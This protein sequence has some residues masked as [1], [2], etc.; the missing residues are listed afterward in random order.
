MYTKRSSLVQ[1]TFI[2]FFAHFIIPLNGMEW[3]VQLL[4]SQQSRHQAKLVIVVIIIP[5]QNVILSTTLPVRLCMWTL[6]ETLEQWPCT[7]VTMAT[8]L[9]GSR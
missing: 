3:R 2:L 1:S 6:Y 8:G 7:D 9:T 4:L 5:L